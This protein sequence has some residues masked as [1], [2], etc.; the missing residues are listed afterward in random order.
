[1]AKADRTQPTPLSESVKT[2]LS[3]LT[4]ELRDLFYTLPLNQPVPA[5]EPEEAFTR[6]RLLTALD[7]TVAARWHW[8]DTRKVLR[9]LQIIH[10]TGKTAGE[11]CIEQSQNVVTPRYAEFLDFNNDYGLNEVRYP[12]LCL[13]LYADPLVLNGRLDDRVDDMV[14]VLSFHRHIGKCRLTCSEART[15]RRSNTTARFDTP[16]IC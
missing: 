9:S 10:E 1:M 7:P 15:P 4:P 14:K 3:L 16:I 8:K 2:S 13:W 11:L 12:T 5:P 6:H